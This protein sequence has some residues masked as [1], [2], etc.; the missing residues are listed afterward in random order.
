M[1]WN[2][3]IGNEMF[4]SYELH[5]KKKNLTSILK[6]SMKHPTKCYQKNKIN[7]N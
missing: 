1:K 3:K 4:G 6:N 7:I 2:I 5:N